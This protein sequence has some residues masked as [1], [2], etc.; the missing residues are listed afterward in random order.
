[1]N[2]TGTWAAASLAATVGL[3][4]RDMFAA[5]APNV[6]AFADTWVSLNMGTLVPASGSSVTLLSAKVTPAVIGAVTPDQVISGARICQG[7]RQ[8]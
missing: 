3:T 5:G 7:L 4:V 1:V 8:Q 6:L 2:I